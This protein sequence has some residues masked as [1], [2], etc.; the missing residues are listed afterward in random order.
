MV[1]RGMVKGVSVSGAAILTAAVVALAAATLPIA[2]CAAGG[3]PGMPAAF[4]GPTAQERAQAVEPALTAAGFRTVTP[5]TPA[6]Q[7]QL[8]SLPSF[9]LNYY[10]SKDGQAR[11]W[12]ADPSYCHCLLIGDA[13][14]YQRYEDLSL[15]NQM[16]ENQQQAQIRQQQMQMMGP[17]G[18]PLMGGPFGFG[19]GGP[20][21]G[22]TF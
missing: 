11:Y 18:P 3:G 5:Q 16:I 1:W 2:G 15:Q 6:H 22:V 21:F 8:A 20:G 9:K 7:Q 4:G 12:F 13:A 10:V 19:V 14:A 17:P